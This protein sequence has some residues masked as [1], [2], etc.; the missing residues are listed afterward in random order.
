MTPLT[1]KRANRW[2]AQYNPLRGLTIQRAVSLLEEGERGRYADLQWLYRSI[3]KREA[4]LRA[5]KRLRLAA[6][7]RLDWDIKMVD[8]SPAA[9]TQ[10]DA[11]RAAYDAI[12]NL[13]EAIKFLAL[14]EFRGFA[15]LE[16]RYQD[17]NPANPVTCLEKVEQWHWA[18]E[19]LYSPWHYDADAS[20][21]V[22][23]EP[24]DPAHF[25]IREVDD[26]INE[27]GLIAY[28]RKN[29]SQKDWDGFVETYGIPPLF[30][31]LPPNVPVEKEAEYQA[32]M[33]AVIGDF[34]G[35]VPH[36]ADVK[37]LNSGERGTNP[38]RQHLDY[39]DEQ[40]VLAGTSGKLTMLTDATGLGS[41]ASGTHDDIFDQLAEDEAGVISEL[42]QEQ[43]DLP[44]L[45]AKFSGQPVLA[46]FQ[47]AARD[48]VDVG[49]ILEHA[50]KANQAGY[51]IDA[52]QLA[53]KTGYTLTAVQKVPPGMFGGGP[54]VPGLT[55]NRAAALAGNDALRS[56]SLKRLAAALDRD[57]APLRTRIKVALENADDAA[58]DKS[59]AELRADLPKLLK[60]HGADSAT[61]KAFEEIYG[62]ALVEGAAGGR[63]QLEEAAT[64]NRGLFTWL[65]DFFTR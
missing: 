62:T 26:P 28:L 2:R 16:K 50:V 29:L 6:I 41:G 18:R 51:Q 47:I 19:D 25:I 14:A 43:F 30:G 52:E 40:L 64:R 10:A 59:L 35:T 63:A 5:L 22:H 27:I 53:E 17:D 21:R 37:T 56:A 65:R 58:L 32:M 12:E 11:L 46:Y 8:D 42:F 45:E 20:G 15:H 55:L 39:Q 36:G 7:G 34:R 57:L 33:E 13:N 49:Q 23:G 44:L 60:K 54:G 38:F 9:K 31:V 3:E 24:I 4:T 1:L 61:A 48:Q